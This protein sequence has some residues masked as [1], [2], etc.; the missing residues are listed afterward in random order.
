M[1]T[2]TLN[3]N[4]LPVLTWNHFNVNYGQIQPLRTADNFATDNI[5]ISSNTPTL[6]NK[7]MLND[8][9]FSGSDK[10]RD[11]YILQNASWQKS[12]VIP[13]KKKMEEP[14]ILDINLQDKD[15]L[16][17]VLDI[18]LEGNSAAN[19][20]ICTSSESSFTSQYSDL[21]RIHAANGSKLKLTCLQLLGQSALGFNNVLA[22][23][24]DNADVDVTQIPLGAKNALA[25]VVANL[26]GYQAHCEIRSDYIGHNEQNIDLNYVVRHYGKKTLADIKMTGL[27][28]G[29]SKK[30][31]RGT[32]DFHRG[33]KGSAGNESENVLML[34]K[35]ARNKSVPLILCDEDDVAGNHGAA[36]GTLDD[37]S[38]FYLKTRGIDQQTAYRLFLDSAISRLKS[39]VPETL[40]NKIDKYNKDVLFNESV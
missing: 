3:T 8:L 16:T 34:S 39:L 15:K 27:L 28:S 38:F 20:I 25:S 9:S 14:I 30:I 10:N 23:V 7:L 32:L 26:S 31:A 21:V 35:T 37:D 22:R 11:D 24:E 4:K 5:T 12:L 36:I 17:S 33:C 18:V 6:E 19:I 29:S 13:D 2:V 1:S 40:A